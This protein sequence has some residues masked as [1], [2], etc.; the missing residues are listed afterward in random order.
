VPL[1]SHRV[2][3][4]PGDIWIDGQQAWEA[5]K[6]ISRCFAKDLD[7]AENCILHHRIGQEFITRHF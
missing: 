7:I 2:D 6:E 5:I 3:I 1:G 4:H